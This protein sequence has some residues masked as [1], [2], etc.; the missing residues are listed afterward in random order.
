MKSVDKY[1]GSWWLDEGIIN[2]RLRNRGEFYL[3]EGSI[4]HGCITVNKMNDSG[5]SK[6]FK[7]KRLFD[8]K[9]PKIII[10]K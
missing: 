7:L 8:G 5:T 6:F 4:S 9:S 2:R 1:G 3:H 10:E